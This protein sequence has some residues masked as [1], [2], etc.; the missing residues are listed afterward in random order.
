M[1]RFTMALAV[2][3]GLAAPAAAQDW[4]S[5][6][7]HSLMDVAADRVRTYLA[8]VPNMPKDILVIPAAGD[9]AWPGVAPADNIRAEV[10]L[11]VPK[12]KPD[13]RPLMMFA[14]R[15]ATGEVYALFISSLQKNPRYR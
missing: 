9:I 1:F 7:P 3:L 4:M 13:A 8:S 12:G 15:P 11:V 2:V 10:W 14:V 5:P 6:P